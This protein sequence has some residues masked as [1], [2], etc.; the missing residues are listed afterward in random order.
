[1]N[2]A[3]TRTLFRAS[4]A[5]LVRTPRAWTSAAMWTAFALVAALVAKSGGVTSGANHVMRGPFADFVLPLVSFS[6]VGG[7]IG[8]G[9]L[10]RSVRGF[11]LLGARSRDAGLARALVAVC[12]SS[13]V[14]AVLAAAVCL[15]A[16]GATDPPLA[17]DLPASFGVAALGGAAYGAFFSAGAAVGKGTLRGFLLAF[18]WMTVETSL[19]AFFPR[20]HVASLLGGPSCADL[21]PRASSAILLL[22]G[23]VYLALAVLAT[24]RHPR[25]FERP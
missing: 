10:A 16:H 15:L 8:E 4:F 23:V 18:D 11:V 19:E 3:L 24:P 20:G 13:I 17:R 5:Q 9:G 21:S 6:V 14:C 12:A 22:L 2:V 1:M 7:A 25:P